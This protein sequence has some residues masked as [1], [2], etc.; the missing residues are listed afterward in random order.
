MEERQLNLEKK[1]KRNRERCEE[2]RKNKL[3]IEYIHIKHHMV[4]KEAEKF[5]TKLNK[6]YPN[7]RDL[8]K[9][10]RY[11]ELKEAAI[12]DN[13]QLKIP[14]NSSSQSQPSIPT[15]IE[16]PPGENPQANIPALAENT[17][18]D[19]I[20]PVDEN[21]PMIEEL[22]QDI[23]ESIVK[24]LRADPNLNRLMNDV[25]TYIDEDMDINL[26]IE[27]DMLEKELV[28]W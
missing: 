4:Y 24:D 14:L 9:T 5:Y 19:E 10:P 27:S 1:R 28:F 16:F 12:N 22:P 15:T 2:H 13:M 7:K 6:I 21:M 26:E 8:L 17:P 23:V 3:M 25:E 18:V 20:T 11:K